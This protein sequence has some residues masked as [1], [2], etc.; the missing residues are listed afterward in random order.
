M[1]KYIIISLLSL[2]TFSLKA[3]I[4]K[5]YWEEVGGAKLTSPNSFQVSENN[6]LA[7]A[8]SINKLYPNQDGGVEA[9]LGKATFMTTLALT[10]KQ[11][12]QLFING[13]TYD[14]KHNLDFYIQPLPKG[15]EV[16]GTLI[17]MPVN[18]TD[19]L[20]ITRKESTI[21]F[22]VNK[23]VIHQ[24]KAD[25]THLFPL[26]AV[27][28]TH[29]REEITNVSFTSS[30]KENFLLK[31]TILPI[32]GNTLGSISI[33]PFGGTAPYTYS[34]GHS[35]ENTSI[36]KGLQQG[37]YNVVITDA[38]GKEVKK[39]YAITTQVSWGESFN[40]PITITDTQY[41][42]NNI[43]VSLKST[44]YIE[45]NKNG[46]L[47]WTEATTKGHMYVGFVPK[48][49]S[50]KLL[51]ND[52]VYAFYM[53]LTKI[54]VV[55]EGKII[56]TLERAK[57][58]N[59]LYSIEKKEGYIIYSIEGKIIAQEKIIQE[60]PLSAKVIL[61]QQAKLT[62]L[63]GIFTATNQ[64]ELVTNTGIENQKQ[65]T[66]YYK[67]QAVIWSENKSE[68]A[69]PAL[70][71][72]FI[73]WKGKADQVWFETEDKENVYKFNTRNLNVEES[74]T[75][76]IQR[77]GY[78]ISFFKEDIFQ[79]TL[80][81][82][83][84]KNLI[85]NAQNKEVD[86]TASFGNCSSPFGATNTWYFGHHAG[87]DFTTSP[88]TA[89]INTKLKANEG[90]GV[91][92]DYN[93]DLLFYTNGRTVWRK[94]HTEMSNGEFETL[95]GHTSSSQTGLVVPSPSNP[96]EYYILHSSA[97]NDGYLQIYYST[98][99]FDADNPLG[100]VDV[101]NVPLN[102]KAF[103]PAFGDPSPPIPSNRELDERMTAVKHKTLNAYW[104]VTHRRE[105]AAFTSFLLGEGGFL[106][107]NNLSL[108]PF[109][110]TTAPVGTFP[111]SK[112]AV[113]NIAPS[114]YY[115][116]I[117]IPFSFTTRTANTD[118]SWALN[119]QFK[120]SPNGKYLA[121]ANNQPLTAQSGV[122]IAGIYVMEYDAA[123]GSIGDVIFSDYLVT[124]ESS[125]GI[126]FSPSGKFL[127]A[128]RK[129]CNNPITD[130]NNPNY[131]KNMGLFQYN[132]ETRQYTGKVDIPDANDPNFPPIGINF[133]SGA[134]NNECRGALQLASDGKIYVT[135]AYTKYLG[136][137]NDPELEL[138]INNNDIRYSETG[139]DLDVTGVEK[140][141]YGLPS[142]VQSFLPCAP[143]TFNQTSIG[144][145]QASSYQLNVTDLT[146][147]AAHEVNNYTYQWNT[148]ATTPNINIF[149]SGTYSLTIKYNNVSCGEVC[150]FDNQVEVL[151]TP[152]STTCE[153]PL[154]I[155]DIYS[156]N[157]YTITAEDGFQDY[158]WNTGEQ[159]RSIVVQNAGEYIVTAF[160]PVLNCVRK[161]IFYASFNEFCYDEIPTSSTSTEYKE[162]L[163]VSVVNYS[164]IWLKNTTDK[165]S[166][167]PFLNAQKG[168]WRADASF[169]YMQDRSASEEVDISKDG[170]FS[171]QMLDWKQNGNVFPSSWKKVATLEQYNAEGFEVEN[172]DILGRY[173]SALYGYQNQLSTAVATN[174]KYHEIVFEGFE[175]Y[176]IKRFEDH[177][178]LTTS[179]LDIFRID[180]LLERFT[181]NI[182]VYRHYNV[183]W[184]TGS[185][186]IVE[187]STGRNMSNSSVSLKIMPV[188]TEAPRI[189]ENVSLRSLNT[190]GIRLSEATFEG[191]SLP[192]QW[193]GNMAF[194]TTAKVT[195]NY[196]LGTEVSVDQN[197]GHTGKKSLKVSQNVAYEQVR[198][199][200]APGRQ[201]VVSLWV[202]V[203]D[204]DVPTF[205]SA[206]D[207]NQEAKRGIKIK[208]EDATGTPIEEFFFEP[209]GRIIEGWQRI[210]GVFCVPQQYNKL[211]LTFQTGN[212][213]THFDDIRFHPF[214]GNLQTYVYDPENYLLRAVLDRNNFATFYYYDSEQQLR[215][216]KKETER[217]I[218]TIQEV[219]SNMPSKQN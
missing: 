166:K 25:Q 196:E 187:T 99:V 53:E 155:T 98:V 172:R 59:T 84:E 85:I 211:Y 72:G 135:R 200:P 56:N 114:F 13:D 19:I 100:R 136:V 182:P 118:N 12:A 87:L 217:G 205:N 152:T 188:S 163:S 190:T 93:G 37:N 121:I 143:I 2:I 15:Y 177:K 213:T 78:T 185:S 48:N 61:L 83:A 89:I 192:S 113:V 115:Y 47:E 116:P 134:A 106:D 161:G 28:F 39:E 94:D 54:H 207:I 26:V 197:Y 142:F 218:K 183:A 111:P 137:I 176:T 133:G 212:K 204:A 66:S 153:A 17:E 21:R 184:G 22:L 92:S 162:V 64:Q 107:P 156:C 86:I 160:D 35:K 206:S 129:Y 165:T 9:E 51:E 108:P 132:I 1:K 63:Q 42:T 131:E 186:A 170:S 75:Y 38:T 148:G 193:K 180:P 210:E 181:A 174:A 173:S 71:D 95:L 96:N 62:Q 109:D 203:K 41:Y 201:Y 208:F 139:V 171:L 43:P 55:F 167:N 11:G 119:G 191:V 81:T 69:L 36:L 126:E 52:L 20:S 158:E 128:V 215:L 123:T 159:G 125:Y 147:I 127:Y 194:K 16:N 138:G 82:D 144:S 27:V 103:T 150:S 76:K 90:C 102:P 67:K 30:Q 145:I 101:K 105:S 31:E 4:N 140:S 202:S 6:V 10:R 44:S 91:V 141:L 97:M 29:S 8:Y 23:K 130:P 49:Q 45:E 34:W 175:E 154:Q 24:V 168:V 73:E 14:F 199:D 68:N 74:A 219:I 60:Y 80:P 157:S 214:N 112:D 209:T 57:N 198:F 178:F 65:T 189:E 110:P 77:S 46:K 70:R 146:N 88:P 40:T 149:S 179:N 216:V 195:P 58:R 3:Q 79:Y 117:T 50:T 5:V 151:L 169:A 124:G 164:D 7:N 120:F 122:S 104:I 33:T 18:A 32:L